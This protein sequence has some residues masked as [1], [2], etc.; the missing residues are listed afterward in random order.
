MSDQYR[1]Q[2]VKNT[3]GLLDR[4]S[5]IEVPKNQ[6]CVKSDNKF[7]ESWMHA[8]RYSKGDSSRGHR[9]A[10]LTEIRRISLV[11]LGVRVDFMR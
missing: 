8:G 6:L 4:S 1:K 5:A 11:Y 7:R 2:T 3:E 9:S 10:A